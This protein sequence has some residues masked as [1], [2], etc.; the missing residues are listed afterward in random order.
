MSTKEIDVT[1][2]RT[3][4]SPR[5]TAGGRRHPLAIGLLAAA[6][7]FIGGAAAAQERPA[8]PG[9]PLTLQT[10]IDIALDANP[11]M[12]AA[13]EGVQVAREAVGEARAPY[14]PEIVL[15]AG[16]TRWQSQA[17]LP[18]GIPGFTDGATIGPT[19]D[20]T[21]G[22]AGRYTLADFGERAA[23][24]R[25]T[26]A[27]QD[28]ADVEVTRVR[29]NLALGVA[30]AFY[31]L[32]AAI[33]SRR[34]G[35]STLARAEEHMALARARRA[36]GAVSGAD[37]IQAQVEVA[38]ARLALVR[39][40]RLV[41]V[42]RGQLTTSMG[43]PVETPV[44]VAP[45]VGAIAPPDLEPMADALARADDRPEVAVARTHV[46]LGDWQVAVAESAFRPRIEA[47]GSYGW[48]DRDFPVG[49]DWRAGV[50]VRWSLFDGHAR[51]HRLGQARAEQARA[52]ADT[53]RVH[54]QVRQDV[55]TA[56]ARLEEAFAAIAAAEVLVRD[57]DEGVRVATER[58][59]VGAGTV[60]E[61][62]DAQSALT[63]ANAA[64]V[65]ARWQYE[66]AQVEYRWSMGKAV[67][68]VS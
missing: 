39:L 28:I 40:D 10:A 51:Q 5:K 16:Y 11:L 43:L 9:A 6:S 8:T 3:T 53:E 34:V 31:G 4:T 63:R 24:L 18:E 68:G 42:A 22:L 2:F 32:V 55:W 12:R 19:N 58:Y 45:S 29:Q 44:D 61:L 67:G 21:A 60:N 23:R 64:R 54:Q 35:E 27:R 25:A 59:R 66:T 56:R 38:D 52:K 1:P 47:E 20:W 49:Q 36:A 7:T 46:T 48:R 57:A 26:L 33:E 14:Y 37:V 41:R 30:Q 50:V 13:R 65:E 62:L 15:R 17:F